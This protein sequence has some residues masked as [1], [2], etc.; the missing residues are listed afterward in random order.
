MINYLMRQDISYGTPTV[1]SL[2]LLLGFL[3]PE[4]LIWPQGANVPILQELSESFS[5]ISSQKIYS[6][7]MLVVN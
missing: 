3:S 4:S 6:S 5:H 1:L 7:L 2:T